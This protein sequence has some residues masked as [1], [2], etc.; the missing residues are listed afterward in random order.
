MPILS[1]ATLDP[2]RRC[3]TDAYLAQ[4]YPNIEVV[5]SDNASTDAT[6]EVLAAFSHDPR[7][8][9]SVNPTNIGWLRNQY[10]A[11][12]LARGEYIVVVPA[13]DILLPSFC[14]DAYALLQRYRTTT[15]AVYA[16]AAYTDADLL[17]YH[18]GHC[19]ALL[20]GA[21]GGGRNEFRELLRMSHIRWNA[22]LAP[23]KIFLDF[24][25]AEDSLH[26][27]ADWDVLLAMS[28]GGV[29]FG[30]LP[31]IQVLTR[32]HGN[33][34]SGSNFLGT[35]RELEDYLTIHERYVTR[36]THWRFHGYEH[37]LLADFQH[38]YSGLSNAAIP[39]FEPTLVKRAERYLATLQQL[40]AQPPPARPANVPRFSVIL[41]TEAKR[42][43]ALRR[44]LA[45]LEAQTETSFEVIV[46]Q[47]GGESV[48][49]WLATLP[50]AQKTRFFH[51]TQS[52]NAASARNIG[53]RLST[54]EFIAYLDDETVFS[55]EHLAYAQQIFTH[56]GV[57]AICANT[58]IELDQLTLPAYFGVGSEYLNP[59]IA[60]MVPAAALV[61]RFSCI[62]QIGP[63]PE[64]LPILD[65]WYLLLSLA[66]HL[67]ITA[68]GA[69]SV[70]LHLEGG[71]IGSPY[72]CAG[73]DVF[74]GILD[75]IYA[76][77]PVP[78]QADT[79]LRSRYRAAIQANWPQPTDPDMQRFIQ[80]LAG[81]ERVA[82][83]NRLTSNL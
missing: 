81:K 38:I 57:A 17:P 34:C 58:T 44:A 37:T 33:Q 35:Y 26:A 25:K 39:P 53:I 75:M 50:L 4:T 21:Y 82:A 52:I 62:E 36:D 51:A 29:R 43:G 63:F 45:S 24:T 56:T 46:I 40:L 76:A 61:H 23:R 30:Y 49:A 48:E 79:D 68:S 9:V 5:I 47:R 22:L 18:N 19:Y 83:L 7:V 27:Q 8:R 12:E 64:N 60:P 6:P 78:T 13:D 66:T 3:A 55:P 2:A 20:P 59:A 1:R 14:A 65:D 73:M 71:F 72:A 77:I 54:G 28:A 42:L 80:T 32:R 15:D 31:S 67:P 70:T 16:S 69:A 74:L 41:T 11:I 10:R